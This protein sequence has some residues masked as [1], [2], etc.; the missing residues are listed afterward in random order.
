MLISIHWASWV[1]IR[2]YI[3]ARIGDRQQLYAYPDPGFVTHADLD[4]WLY[5]FVFFYIIK[6]KKKNL[7]FQ[8][9]IGMDFESPK[10]RI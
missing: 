3:M 2:K 7:G 10:I 6:V 5:F 9:R 4:P 1:R 8:M